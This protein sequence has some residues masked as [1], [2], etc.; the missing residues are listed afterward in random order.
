MNTEGK[1]IY[2]FDSFELDPTERRLLRDGKPVALPP[3][4]F[5]TLVVLVENNSRLVEKEMLLDRVW[6]DSF[7]E[8]GNL[9]ICVHTL[10][11]VLDGK[12]FIETVPKKGYRF[13]A[14]V[15]LIEKPRDD[16]TI[17]KQV[18]SRITIEAGAVDEQQTLAN[19]APRTLNGS[20][21]MRKSYLALGL[22]AAL[23]FG[24]AFYYA[25]N[26][27]NKNASASPFAD[28]KTVAVLP[29][30]SLS[31]PP[32]EQELRVGMA[33][34]I[35]TKLSQVRQIAVRP[36]SATIRYLDKDYDTAAIGKELN[37]DSILEGSVQKEGQT[38]KINL[39]MVSINDG[40]VLWADT[41]TNDL[42]NVLSGQ[43]SVASR[44]SRLLAVGAELNADKA[45]QGSPNLSAQELYLKGRYAMATSAR[46]IG[47]VVQARDFYEQAIRLDP[48]YAA[49]H[50]AL[51]GSY[52]T[53]AALN[54]LAPREAYPKAEIS[55]RR[56]LKLDPNVAEA[57]SV[58]AQIETNYNWNWQAGEAAHRRAIELTPNAAGVH[59]DYAEFLA[60]MGRFQEA[61]YH[62]DLAHQLDPTAI[63]V[64]A[65]KALGYCYARRYDEAVAQ[66][67]A[68]IEKDQNAYLAYLY[69]TIA[70]D[71]KGNY[72][73]ALVAA[74]R[75]S[76]I[77]GGAPPDGFALG[78][79]Y[80]LVKDEAKTKEI[81]AKLEAASRQQYV[82]PFY[83]AMIYA[84]RGDKD[85]AFEYLEKCRAEKSY[86]ITTLKVFPFLDA[87]RSDAR[88]AELLRRVNLAE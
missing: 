13:N 28:V 53:A 20:R 8:E 44:V 17:E 57:H 46:K 48:N 56:A 76:S 12:N 33:D 43:D 58:V 29:L 52:T 69:L 39:Q 26:R 66:S 62:G 21:S 74:E 24:S 4:A 50:A 80:A 88:F 3:K 41:F 25:K 23:L 32:N 77:T 82:D 45:A 75:A 47:N 54:L 61:E 65:V 9:K 5:D 63:N 83:F 42:S 37:V 22:L 70:Q 60:R 87:L 49:A 81:L 84:L 34:S 67:R 55:A 14:P 51:A 7:V 73:D 31:V 30:K 68:V 2:E 15:R 40:R 85:R 64:E 59:G 78:C 16:F 38:L 18:V 71:A 19:D 6:A 36:T 27:Q 79:T 10:R 86:W 1:M 72:A 11:K 35:V